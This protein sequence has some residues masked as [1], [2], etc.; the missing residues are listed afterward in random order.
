MRNLAYVI[1]LVGIASCAPESENEPETEM[2]AGFDTAMLG[3]WD[4]NVTVEGGDSYPLWFELTE[5]AGELSHRRVVAHV[6]IAVS[7]DCSH[8][9]K[10]C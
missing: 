9:R 6:R 3:R 4:G 10:W 8:D 5:D 2:D 1:W 7:S